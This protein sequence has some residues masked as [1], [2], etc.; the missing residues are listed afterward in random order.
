MPRTMPRH[1][2]EPCFSVP[3]T[4]VMTLPVLGLNLLVDFR[5]VRGVNLGLTSP[6][7]WIGP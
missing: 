3:Q 7:S 4:D 6:P 2:L 1:G 5:L